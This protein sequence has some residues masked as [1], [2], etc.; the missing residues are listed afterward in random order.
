M[1]AH[2]VMALPK[3]HVQ[4]EASANVFDTICRSWGDNDNVVEFQHCRWTSLFNKVA[5]SI[6]VS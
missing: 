5:A 6:D 2:I 4:I 1:G 3:R